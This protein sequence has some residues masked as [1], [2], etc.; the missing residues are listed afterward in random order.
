MSGTKH[1]IGQANN[2]FVFPGVGLGAIVAE[3]REVDRRAVP[4]GRRGLAEAVTPA[5][6]AQG[7]LYPSQSELRGVSRQI[8]IQVV[9]AARDCG[10]GRPYHDHDIEAA[11]EAAMWFPD[12]LP[13]IPV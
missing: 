6:L 1:V 11:V 2:A 3:A 7:G 10:F 9:C 13:Y 8:A 12:Y 5:R 4:G